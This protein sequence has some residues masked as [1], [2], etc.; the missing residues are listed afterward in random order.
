MCGRHL[1]PVS[2][3]GDKAGLVNW[4]AQCKWTTAFGFP[5]FWSRVGAWEDADRSSGVR[6]LWLLLFSRSVVSD[7][8]AAPWIGAFWAPP[9]TGFP[10]QEYWS[11]LPGYK[12]VQSGEKNI[13]R[14][15]NKTTNGR[16]H[17]VSFSR[18]IIVRAPRNRNHL[19]FLCR[20]SRREKVEKV[21]IATMWSLIFGNQ[22]GHV[23]LKQPIPVKKPHSCK[24]P[25]K[26]VL[27]SSNKLYFGEGCCREETVS[28][29]YFLSFVIA[30]GINVGFTIPVASTYFC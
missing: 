24:V 7:S 2:I 27:E 22:L 5:D 19:C 30:L 29:I 18:P 28:T 10:R 11:G 4:E 16:T 25:W 8:S 12:T 26:K 6:L 14:K 21:E 3:S 20:G 1:Q 17:A 9:S 15:T 23:A 13:L